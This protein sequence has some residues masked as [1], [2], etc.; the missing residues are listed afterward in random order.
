MNKKQ[1]NLIGRNRNK[2]YSID[3]VAYQLDDMDTI[4]DSTKS[5]L[6]E[7]LSLLPRD[8]VDFLANE[9]T[10][11][12]QDS[13]VDFAEHWTF[14]AMAFKKRGSENES[15]TG[16][17][18]INPILWGTKKIQITFSIAHE[19]AHAYLGHKKATM[20]DTE[21]T[22]GRAQEVAAD[23]QAIKWLKRHYPEKELVKMTYI[24]RGM[25]K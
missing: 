10:F 8:V 24:G 21:P 14:D 12:C 7:A 17:I 22:V 5:Y 9:Y 2:S 20:E 19:V 3:M 1:K 15:K 13:M 16:F 11:I 6:F 23:S 4:S 18:L 25:I